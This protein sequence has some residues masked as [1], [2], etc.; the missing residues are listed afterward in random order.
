MNAVFDPD[1]DLTISRVIKA[2]RSVVWN[3]WADPANFEQW[4]IP[5]P[6]KC[7]V[8]E[9]YLQAAHSSRR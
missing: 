7:K 9:V 5:A 3:A 4:W 6:A 1:L 2:P 8:V